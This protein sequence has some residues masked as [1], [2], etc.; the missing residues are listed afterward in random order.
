MCAQAAG[1][2]GGVLRQPLHAR[3]QILVPLSPQWASNVPRAEAVSVFMR[4][5]Q[6]VPSHRRVANW[7]S[8]LFLY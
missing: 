7:V 3:S 4:A 2:C 1:G 8:L 6:F 5:G